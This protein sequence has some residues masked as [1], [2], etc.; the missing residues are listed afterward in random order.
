MKGHEGY[1]S[2]IHNTVLIAFARRRTWGVLVFV[3]GAKALRV[4]V[5]AQGRHAKQMFHLNGFQI[6]RVCKAAHAIAD[7]IERS[8]GQMVTSASYRENRSESSPR[9]SKRQ[10]TETG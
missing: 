2:L 5:T 9:K 4:K 7:R 8:S 1:Y 3:P 6:V 10:P